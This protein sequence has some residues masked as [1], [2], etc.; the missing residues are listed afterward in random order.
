MEYL[1]VVTFDLTD[2]DSNDYDNVNGALE[3]IELRQRLFANGEQVDLPYNT[4]A[5]V[6]E[7][8]RAAGEL[9]ARLGASVRACFIECG[10]VGKAFVSVGTDWSWGTTTT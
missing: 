1:G 3:A 8:P 9:R 2:A 5:G 10:V 7:W 6:F 4:Y